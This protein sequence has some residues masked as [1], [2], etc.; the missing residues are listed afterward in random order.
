MDTFLQWV[1]FFITIFLF[2][3]V[4]DFVTSPIKFGKYAAQIVKAYNLE[5]NNA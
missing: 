5:M 4:M 3:S 1:R 2:F